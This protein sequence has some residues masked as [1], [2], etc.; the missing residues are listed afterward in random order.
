M[1]P[2]ENWYFDLP[3]F[4]AFLKKRVEALETDPEVRPIVPQT[5]KEFLAP[6]VVYIKK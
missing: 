5:I 2:V 1:R 4:N 6:P 3:A